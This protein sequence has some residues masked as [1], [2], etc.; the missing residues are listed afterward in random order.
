MNVN[1][2]VFI[3]YSH[4]TTNLLSNGNSIA[5]LLE[6]QFNGLK[7]FTKNNILFQLITPFNN[8]KINEYKII[9]LPYLFQLGLQVSKVI[10][11]YKLKKNIFG[12]SDFEYIC[13]IFRTAYFLKYI[14]NSN[15][16][17]I[18]HGS[19]RFLLLLKYFFK[20]RKIIYYHHGGTLDR[21]PKNDLKVLLKSICYRLISVSKAAIIPIRNMHKNIDYIH[22]GLDQKYFQMHL[23]NYS[24]I[25]SQVRKRLKIDE[26]AFCFI[27]GGSMRKEK[28]YALLIDCL[29][30]NN[31]E[32]KIIVLVVGDIENNKDDEFFEY[33]NIIINKNNL[34]VR[35]LGHLKQNEL[36]N[37][38]VAGD[39]GFQLSSP[40]LSEGISIFILEMMFLRLP[41][42]VSDSGGNKEIVTDGHSGI[43]LSNY[44]I[45]DLKKAIIRMIS[46]DNMEQISLNAFDHVNKN[47]SSQ[48]MTKKMIQYVKH[49]D[50]NA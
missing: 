5:K 50:N 45:E 12:T 35:F 27:I 17:I 41:V 33:L 34:D 8:A 23:K 11:P 7:L 26:N 36:Y 38:I 24:K 25:K 13:H 32:R 29:A 18:I 20:N 48:T 28:G 47:F 37:I 2:R 14:V 21:I 30:K 44:N 10:L 4:A 22:N 1:R 42:I 49:I 43:T 15:D 46:F 19:Y 16:I 3:T 31:F 39:I 6:S 40:K 9:R